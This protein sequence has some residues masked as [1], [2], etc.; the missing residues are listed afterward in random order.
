MRKGRRRR[1]GEYSHSSRLVMGAAT[2]RQIANRPAAA[3]LISTTAAKGTAGK[4]GRPQTRNNRQ[5]LTSN[6]RTVGAVLSVD[7]VAQSFVIDLHSAIEVV[8]NFGKLVL[9]SNC[10]VEQ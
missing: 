1:A 10:A 5:S 8:L 7:A 9:H 4:T 6:S 2:R 3:I